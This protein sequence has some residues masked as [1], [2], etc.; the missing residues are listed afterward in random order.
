MKNK[1]LIFSLDVESNGLWGQPFTIAAIV[2]EIKKNPTTKQIKLIEINKICL[3]MTNLAITDT[4]VKENVLPTLNFPVT[5][6]IN[7][8]MYQL[9]FKEKQL[10]KAYESMLRDFSNFYLKYKDA[11]I[12][13][14]MGHIVESNL[15]RE[16]HRLNFIGDWDAPYTP[17]D[18][19]DYL[20]M[21]NEPCDSVDSYVKKYNIKIN[22]YGSTHNPLYDCEVASRVYEHI[23]NI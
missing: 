18:V 12:L 17:I 6:D 5:H 11:T 20:R 2:Y 9:I 10:Q 3:R 21:L 19:A 16:M 14:H 4:W 13:Y 23:V 7:P 8:L 1:N 22:N 15:F